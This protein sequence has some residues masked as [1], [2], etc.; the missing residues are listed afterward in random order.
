ML[1]IERQKQIGDILLEKKSVS[2]SELAEQFQVSYE[3]IRRDL[4]ELEKSGMAEKS[5]GGAVLKERVT[6]KLGFQELS[7]IMVDLKHRIAATALP[8]IEEGDSIYIDFST[9]CGSIVNL[10]GDLSINV[11]TNSLEVINRLSDKENISLLS[12]GGSWDAEN[13]AFFGRTAIQT[14]EQFHVDKAFISCCALSREQGITDRTE[15][16]SELRRKVIESANHIYLLADYS[17]FDKVAFVKTCDFDRIT[18]IVTDAEL[19]SEW[20]DFL[21]KNHIKYYCALSE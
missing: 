5:Y 16:E 20:T 11:L 6:H 15:L 4:R 21:K 2:V 19:D 1:T 13:R 8:L 12:T 18:G 7:K 14:L 10:L 3:T 9:T 17:K